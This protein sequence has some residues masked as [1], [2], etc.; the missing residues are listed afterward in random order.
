[1]LKQSIIAIG[2][3]AG[4]L[5]PLEVFFEHT[6]LDNASYII[7]R[8]LPIEYQSEL[9]KILKRHSKLQVV[10]AIEGAS[11]EKDMV[12][13]APPWYH[14]IIRDG[15]LQFVARTVGPNRAI[16]TF[17][18]SLAK[19]ENK[20]KAIAVIFSGEGNDG[21]EGAAAIKDAGGL[22]IVQSP[23]SCEYPK[24]PLA[25]INSGIADYVL[26]P[27][28]MPMIIHGYVNRQ[29]YENRY[30]NGNYDVA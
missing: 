11:I 22:V 27:R 7:L 17:M 28:D 20:T 24:L 21:I 9:N 29:V 16:D 19:N 8:H 13:Y 15:T 3:S 4:S 6:P 10:E 18:K 5:S 12:Y 2:G 1:M 30:S 26:L 25:V 23:E 14:L